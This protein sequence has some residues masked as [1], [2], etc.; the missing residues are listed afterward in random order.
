L[1]RTKS[2]TLRLAED[3]RGLRIDATLDPTDPDVQRLIP[4]MKRGDMSQM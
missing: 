2:G 1:A 3:E 4:K